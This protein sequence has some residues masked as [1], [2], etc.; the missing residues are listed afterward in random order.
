M[1]AHLA[2]W[3]DDEEFLAA[4]ALEHPW[5][6]PDTPSLVAT[7]DGR[8][9]GWIAAAAR[10]LR[11]GDRE[12]R[13]VCCSHLVVDP[14]SRSSAA[15]A[16]LLSRL[17][18]GPQEL[19]WSDSANDPV[20]RMWRVYG[21]HIDHSRACDWMLV[22]RPLRWLGGI[23]A[24]LPRRGAASREL[25]PVAAFPFQALGARRGAD[26]NGGADVA[27][28][29]VG[30]AEIAE[31]WSALTA[32]RR[33]S[34]DYDKAFLDQLFML[35]AGRNG[36]LTVRLVRRGG[37]PIGLYVCIPGR[38]GGLRVLHL[39]GRERE[40]PAVM[41]ELVEHARAQG[42]RFLF[43]RLEPHLDAPVRERLAAIGLA[44]RPI[45]HSRDPELLAALQ[46]DAAL[47]TRLD[48]EWFWT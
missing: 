32:K 45:V 7:E 15:G 10:R 37:T 5:A 8:V 2:G 25:V 11:F 48:S 40:I 13:G 23:A 39:S 4:T 38:G 9:V 28:E 30:P 47:L 1:R 31:N 35:I 27:G 14:A 44:R 43:G 6:D 22:L 46:T 20:L 18:S 17:L 34:L 26:S 12:I 3:N 33:I 24:A 42:V 29:D 41:D 21:G 36:P 19:T 16:L